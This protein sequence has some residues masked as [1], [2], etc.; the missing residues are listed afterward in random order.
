MDSPTYEHDPYR[1][2]AEPPKPPEPPRRPPAPC[3]PVAAALGNA[4]LLGIGYLLLGRWR[5]AAL[6]VV[7][8][9][10][11]LNLTASTAETWCEILLLLWWAA[12]IAHGWFLAHRRAEHVVRRGQRAGALAVTVAVLLT[13]VLLRVDAYG[14]ED[15]VNEAREGG[16]CEAA[17]AAQ[18]E[19]W[20]GHRLAGA[21]VVEPGDAVVEACHR[22]ERAASTLAG[23]GRNGNIEDLERGFGILAGVLSKPGNEQTVKTVLDTFLEG[24]PT[25][26]SCDTADITDWLRDRD[27]TRDVLDRSADTAKRTE[28]AALVGCG[29]DLMDEDDWQQARARY[30]H[31]LDEY[32]DDARTDEARSGVKKAT[33]AIELDTVRRLVENTSDAKSGYCDTP[34]KYSGAPPYRKGFNRAMFLGDTEY[35]DKLPRDWRTGDPTKAALVVCADTAKNG[36]A[37]ETCY[38]ENDKSEYLPHEVTFYKVKIPLKVYELRTGKRV[39]PREVQISG[40]SCPRVLHYEYYGWYDYGP[41]GDEFVSTAKSDVRDAFWPVIKR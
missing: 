20:W 33:L 16:D 25:K 32:P 2:P 27:P 22:L 13:A 24:L 11:L 1:P 38:Y 19:V 6:A 36:A 28:P 21:P 4:S 10:W 18:G 35:T 34:A 40:G 3:D 12:G 7:G 15:R 5:L 9:G 8:T 31:L 41:G 14:I 23:A 29:D 39:D 30:Q 17:V 37:V 26:D